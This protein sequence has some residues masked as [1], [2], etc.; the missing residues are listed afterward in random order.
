M[1]PEPLWLT[2][3]WPDD[4]E[5]RCVRVGGH[6]VCRRCLALYPTGFLV[7]FAAAL[8]ASPW[9]D[10]WDPAAIWLACLPATVAFVGE[11]VG[12][13][14]YRP[15][16]QSAM[17]AIT[18]LGFGKALSYELRQRWS[19]QFWWPLGVFAGIWFAASLYQV[20]KGNRSAPPDGVDGIRLADRLTDWPPAPSETPHPD[21]DTPAERPRT[22]SPT[23]GSGSA[24]RA[25]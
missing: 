10:R 3:H 24:T 6:H 5:Q 15:R 9:P 11:A 13:F 16:W 21:P 23:A 25:D 12:L 22:A 18:S 20:T 8:G 1:A 4:Y 7:A 2:H 19:P 17:M 14:A